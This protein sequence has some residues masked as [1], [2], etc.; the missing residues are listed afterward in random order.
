MTLSTSEGL[1][2]VEVKQLLPSSQQLLFSNFY[3]TLGM[4]LM[5]DRQII[6][7]GQAKKKRNNFSE[8][9]TERGMNELSVDTNLFNKLSVLLRQ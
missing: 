2:E 4:T 9:K 1:A 6:I 8:L 3:V 7:T 5:Q